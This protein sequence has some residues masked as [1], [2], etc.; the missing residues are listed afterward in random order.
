LFDQQKAISTEKLRSETK[1]NPQSPS[2]IS[3]YT[4]KGE[5]KIS[6]IRITRNKTT[7]DLEE[8]NL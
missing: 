1:E 5:A 2:V 4:G 7:K 8:L 6:G 3:K